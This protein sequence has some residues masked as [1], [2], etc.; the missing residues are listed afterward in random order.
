MCLQNFSFC[1][2]FVA[3]FIAETI[4]KVCALASF[5]CQLRVS[6]VPRMEWGARGAFVVGISRL[7]FEWMEKMNENTVGI[8]LP[9]AEYDSLAYER[10]PVDVY[11]VS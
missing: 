6:L 9:V 10:R 4:A 2:G 8:Y 11:P 1:L 5:V 3:G 7:S